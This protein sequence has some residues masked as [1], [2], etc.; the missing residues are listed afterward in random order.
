MGNLRIDKPAKIEK[1]A[2]DGTGRTTVIS[3]SIRFPRS[4]TV[5]NPVGIGGRIYWTDSF[6]GT[7]DTATLDGGGRRNLMGETTVI[8]I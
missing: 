2:M 7:V 8:S 6:H 4:I 3:H 5:D 1:A